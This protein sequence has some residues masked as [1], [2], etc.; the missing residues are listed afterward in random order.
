MYKTLVLR[1]YRAAQYSPAKKSTA[2]TS[3]PSSSQ[4]SA[5]DL[6]LLSSNGIHLLLYFLRRS[7]V[8]ICSYFLL[9]ILA[10]GHM[11][12]TVGAA[13][14]QGR[15]REACC[16]G[17]TTWRRP[18]TSAMIE[19]LLLYH[20]PFF[21]RYH[22]WSLVVMKDMMLGKLQG[23]VLMLCKMAIPLSD[24]CEPSWWD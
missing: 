14:C 24:W 11:L 17:R 23:L 4:F 6:E 22:S 8:W 1:S 19:L 21:S 10:A 7:Q 3:K 9:E 15:C 12:S 5:F 18:S 20:I 13:S 2:R 16:C